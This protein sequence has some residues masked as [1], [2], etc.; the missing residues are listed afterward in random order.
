[1]TLF[2]MIHIGEAAYY[3]EVYR[4][5]GDHDVMLVEGVRSPLSRAITSSYRWMNL[6]R[7]GL[8]VQPR[9]ARQG[10]VRA[11][12]VHADLTGAEF[13]RE[14]RKVPWWLRIAVLVMAP[15]VG[16]R[17]RFSTSRESVA[18]VAEMEDR[19]SSDELLSW[20]PTFA[21]LNRCILEVRDARLVERLR[22]EL[23]RIGEQPEHRIA[24]V[25][26]ARHMRAVL[27][28]LKR[29]QFSSSKA[30]WMTIFSF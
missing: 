27:T 1:V 2:P 26:G 28:E 21:A 14:W 16:L 24:V 12:I 6:E 30:S 17:R 13:S 9:H 7:L 19:L 18:K 5:A 22:E 8:V 25:F 20:D 29:R 11:R 10:M 4:D 15:L 23:D 3:A